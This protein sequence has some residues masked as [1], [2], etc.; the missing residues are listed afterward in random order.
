MATGKV[1]VWYV[2][3]ADAGA[4]F[5]SGFDITHE[6]GRL[7]IQKRSKRTSSFVSG[8]P[9][10]ACWNSVPNPLNSP[11]LGLAARSETER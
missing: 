4:F 3:P 11:L 9:F 6:I 5:V 10:F 2:S 8:S 1:V 7:Y